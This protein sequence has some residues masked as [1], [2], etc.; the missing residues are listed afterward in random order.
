MV[1]VAEAERIIFLQ[2]RDFGTEIVSFEDCLGRVLAE[3]LTADRDFPPFNRVTMDGI[4]INFDAFRNGIRSF[5]IKA[6]QSAGESPIDI[7]ESGEC[8]EIMTGAA[9]P[10]TTDTVI[11]Y[12]EIEIKNGV[13][14]INTDIVSIGQN[15]HKK[16]KDKKQSEILAE[17]NQFIT[18]VIL[19]VAA[20]IGKTALLVKRCPRIIIIST[21]DEMVDI[22]QTPA[23]SQ[24][25][26]SNNYTLEAILKELS[27]E[28]AMLHLPDDQVI[29]EEKLKQCIDAFDVVLLSGGVSMGKFDF[30]P[31]ALEKLQVKNLF[32]KVQQRPGKPFWFGAHQNGA[33]VFAFPGNPVS[34]FL[35]MHRYFLPWLK[36]SL[37]LKIKNYYALLDEHFIFKPALQYFLQ[38][39]LQVNTKG[40]WLATP[41][42]GNGS[43]DFA[44]LLEADAFM[45]LPLEQTDFRK[46][47]VFPVWL[48]K[49]TLF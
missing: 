6:I 7:S 37:Q 46:G 42:E 22:N 17:A 39:K 2:H 38:V 25:R 29:I 31:P 14:I 5:K 36:T 35:C 13:A 28:A 1:S 34:T 44:N 11:P 4:A 48:F 20:T 3:N 33:L 27:I 47:D 21:G 40:E 10:A 41:L 49:Q 43:G 26:R 23:S 12:E 8:I 16:G 15:I 24:I 19:S 30:V 9:L 45:E 32:Y 18:P